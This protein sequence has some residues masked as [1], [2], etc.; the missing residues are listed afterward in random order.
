MAIPGEF[1]RVTSKEETRKLM[2]VLR[3]Q[4]EESGVSQASAGFADEIYA[5]DKE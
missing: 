1:P 5:E 3:A 2:Q 4:V